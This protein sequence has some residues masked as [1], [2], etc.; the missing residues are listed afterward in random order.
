MRKTVQKIAVLAAAGL[1][2]SGLGAQMKDTLKE[3]NIEE[4]VVTALGIK[5]NKKRWDT[6]PRNLKM[7]PSKGRS[8][9]ILQ[10]PWKVKLPD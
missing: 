7:K 5:E 10:Q 4:V 3:K 8:T 6:P 9:G 2:N 1:L